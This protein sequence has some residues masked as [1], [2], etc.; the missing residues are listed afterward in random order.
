[1]ISRCTLSLENLFIKNSADIKLVGRLCLF[2]LCKDKVT[3]TPE[4]VLN[5]PK[6]AVSA[7]LAQLPFIRLRLLLQPC[8]A[9]PSPTPH[10]AQPAPSLRLRVSRHCPPSPPHP[11]PRPA[12]KP[13]CM[14]TH[15]PR[16][17]VSCQGCPH[18]HVTG[19]AG[20]AQNGTPHFER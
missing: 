10:T 2:I 9:P 3:R 16:I 14:Q 5:F 4:R 20:H 13:T 18:P 7:Q 8:I 6:F 1:M 19:P 11:A 17:L 15:P 12:V